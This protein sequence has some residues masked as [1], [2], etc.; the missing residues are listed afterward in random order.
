[1]KRILVIV[2]GLKGY[3]ILTVG[4]K[5][6]GYCLWVK[7]ILVIVCGLK[8]YWILTVGEKDIGFG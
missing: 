3:W 1:M 6:I 2:C 7:R 5:D 4:E 8:G